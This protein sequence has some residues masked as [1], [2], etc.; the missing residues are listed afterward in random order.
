MLKED[1][2]KP[3]MKP[4]NAPREPPKTISQQAL[5]TDIATLQVLTLNKSIDRSQKQT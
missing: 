2:N 5:N 3:L 4:A 1:L